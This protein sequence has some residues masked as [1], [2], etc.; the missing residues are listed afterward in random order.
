MIPGEEIVTDRL[1]LRKIAKAEAVGVAKAMLANPERYLS[2]SKT[3][4]M[5]RQSYEVY[6][7]DS[8]EVW[9][10][11]KNFR[12]GIWLDSEFAGVVGVRDV[13][14]IQGSAE[15]SYF[16]TLE[17]EG[18]GVAREACQA[19]IEHVRTQLGLDYLIL[20]SLPINGRSVALAERLGFKPY[21]VLRKNYKTSD[22]VMRDVDVYRLIL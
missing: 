17:M 6:L 20:R 16:I 8:E 21:G 11:G 19:L 7:A 13:H 2:F 15:L 18:R 9:A 10:R 4:G 3:L 22:G 1:V 5:V 12:F 14:E